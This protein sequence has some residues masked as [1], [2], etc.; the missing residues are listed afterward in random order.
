MGPANRRQLMMD[1]SHQAAT[2]HAGISPETTIARPG[3]DFRPD[4]ARNRWRRIGSPQAGPE[5]KHVPHLDQ[6]GR[7]G[8]SPE[9]NLSDRGAA[10][11][12]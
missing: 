5:D 3:Q 11:R 12:I 10:E 4:L 1:T 9:G 8:C 7:T 2:I 6:A